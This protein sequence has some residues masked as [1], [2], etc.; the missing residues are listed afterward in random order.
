MFV[1]AVVW[2]VV[3][4]L[5]NS[6]FNAANVPLAMARMIHL[7]LEEG[8]EIEAEGADVSFMVCCI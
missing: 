6:P 1:T 3:V 2:V 4:N 7:A 8:A 5:A